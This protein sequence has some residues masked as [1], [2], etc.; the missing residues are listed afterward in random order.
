MS[1]GL[2]KFMPDPTAIAVPNNRTL[3]RYFQRAGDE[4]RTRVLSLGS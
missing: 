4:N 2:S 3:T 1:G